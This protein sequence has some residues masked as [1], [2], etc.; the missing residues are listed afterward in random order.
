MNINIQVDSSLFNSGPPAS[1]TINGSSSGTQVQIATNRASPSQ[2]AL[3]EPISGNSNNMYNSVTFTSAV[4][5]R[6]DL[7]APAGG[8]QQS[9]PP[10]AS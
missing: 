2:H 6:R 3:F 4:V 1:G 9:A 5:Q 7:N 8:M 10:S